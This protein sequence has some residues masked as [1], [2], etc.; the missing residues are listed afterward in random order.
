MAS[1]TDEA[2]QQAQRDAEQ[3]RAAAQ[4]HTWNHSDRT[5]YQAEYDRQR[6]QQRK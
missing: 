5:N 6:E 4:T 3:N 1:S 2:R